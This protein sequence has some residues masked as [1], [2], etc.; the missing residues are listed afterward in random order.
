MLDIIYSSRVYELGLLFGWG[1][2][3]YLPGDMTGKN[4][5]AFASSV[6]KKIKSAEKAMQKDI[7]L[8]AAL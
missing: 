7:D 3:F 2:L 5:E 6:E 1:N 4:S 8:F